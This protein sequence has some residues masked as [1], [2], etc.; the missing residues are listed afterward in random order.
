MK[1]FI[2]INKPKDMTS[3]DVVAI[4]RGILRKA[5]GEKQH[6]GHFGTLDPMGT[7]VLPIAIGTATRLFDY[8]VNKVKIYET[9]FVF[10]FTTDTLDTTG[11]VV[12]QTLNIPSKDEIQAVLGSLIGEQ[13]QIPPM[14][15]AKSVNGRRAYDI[16]RKGKAV[17]LNPRRIQIYSIE[18]TGEVGGNEYSFLIKCSGGTYIRSIARDL[19]EK[20]NSLAV[21]SSINRIKSGNFEISDS[22]TIDELSNDPLKYI[23]P[24]ETEL[25]DMPKYVVP[26]D[27]V[28]KVVNG[29]K[30]EMNNLPEGYFVV[31]CNGDTLG[32]GEN[33]NGRLVVRTRL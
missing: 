20:L 4:V 14:Y 26:E 25:K 29:V 10:G 1:G 32:I 17:E 8:A 15:S 27:K 31:I 19:G 7:G 24:L 6:T 16:A 3:S 28:F 2:N 33:N 18:M 9:T 12:E 30:I 5:T 13:D 11:K 22:V 23:L 21:M